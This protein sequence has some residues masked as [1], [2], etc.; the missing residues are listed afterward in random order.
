[1]TLLM[2]PYPLTTRPIVVTALVCVSRLELAG[3]LLF[4]VLK[5]GKDAR[6]D[7]VREKCCVFFV[8]W[9]WQMLW[10]YVVSASVIYINAAG[11]LARAVPL[12]AYDG[13]GWGVFLFGFVVQVWSDLDK[14]NFRSDPANSKKVCGRGLW[15]WSRHPNFCGEV[16]MWVGIYIAGAPVFYASPPGWATLVSPLFTLGVL[17]LF[18]G[19]PQVRILLL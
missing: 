15:K 2:A 10:V 8:F 18:T 9:V 11:D 12:G 16:L 6:F 1:M 7:Q 4:R 3:F 19:I 17:T 5:R 13:V 14:Y